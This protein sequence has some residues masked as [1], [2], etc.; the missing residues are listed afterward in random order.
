MMRPMISVI[1]FFEI[2]H[3]REPIS[4]IAKNIMYTHFEQF[5]VV[6]FLIHLLRQIALIPTY[7]LIHRRI[8]LTGQW[9]T[10]RT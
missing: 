3:T 5:T 1:E 6:S 9:L 7:L 2:A 4:N 8:H 10:H